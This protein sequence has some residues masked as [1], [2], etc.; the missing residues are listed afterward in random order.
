MDQAEQT[1]FQ[2]C[3]EKEI[4]SKFRSEKLQLFKELFNKGRDE[5]EARLPEDDS[6]LY[7]IWASN[8]KAVYYT[9]QDNE[10]STSTAPAKEADPKA[11]KATSTVTNSGNDSSPSI[12][13][14][15]K[16]A[17][18]STTPEIQVNPEIIE[19]PSSVTNARNDSPTVKLFLDNQAS[20]STTP[21][22]QANSEK[23]TKSNDD[24][25]SITWPTQVPGEKGMTSEAIKDPSI[26]STIVIPCSSNQIK[27]TESTL[28]APGTSHQDQIDIE[29]PILPATEKTPSKEPYLSE[30]PNVDN[31]KPSMKANLII[32]SPFKRNLFWP[33]EDNTTKKTEGKNTFCYHRRAMEKIL[34]KERGRE[35]TKRKRKGEKSQ[36]KRREENVK[37]GTKKTK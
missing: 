16:G 3:L 15:E 31:A 13:C 30:N 26:A 17:S 25:L 18:T 11:I 29:L 36:G 10:A 14:L 33:K 21:K 22:N 4:I 32:P 34:R 6:S 20:T 2:R 35:G 8:K 1:H 23:V 7:V 9:C 28:S 27:D 12:L 19:A 37:G 24:S 5:V